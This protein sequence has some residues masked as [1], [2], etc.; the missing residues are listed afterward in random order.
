MLVTDKFV[1]LHLPRTGGTFVY[2]VVTRFFPSAREIGYHLPRELLP[3]EFSGLPILGTV[4]NPWD[5]Y[6][7]WY[8][9]QQSNKKYSRQKNILFGCLSNDRQHGFAETIQNALDLG[10]NDNKLDE[11]ILSVPDEVSYRERH[12]PNLTKNLVSRIRGSGLGLYT[13]RFNQLFGKADDVFFCR[14]ESLRS[15]LMTF[16]EKI[17]A[18]TEDL[19]NYVASLDKKNSSAHR[20]YSTYYTPALAA[21]VSLRDRQLVERFGFTFEDGAA[22]S[23]TKERPQLTKIL[24]TTPVAENATVPAKNRLLVV[25]SREKRVIPLRMGKA[26]GKVILSGNTANRFGRRALAVPVD[27]YISAMWEPSDTNRG[28]AIVWDSQKEDGVWL[29]TVRKI[30]RLIE[31]QIGP[32]SGRLTIHNTLPLGRGMG[33]STAIV[34]AL[35]RCFLGNHC[36]AEALAIEDDIN[37]GHSGL[38]FAAIW[39]ARPVIIQGDRYA[40]T[41]LPTG[42]QHGFLIDTGLPEMPT[43]I[44]VRRLKERLLEDKSLMRSVDIIGNCTERLLGGEHPLTVYPDHHREFVKLGLIPRNVCELV[45]KIERSGGAAKAGRFGGVTGGVGMLF[46]VHPEIQD[47]KAVVKTA[48]I[49]VSYNARDHTFVAAHPMGQQ[50]LRKGLKPAAVAIG[51]Y[52]T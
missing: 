33:S 8:H 50:Y 46:V 11:L 36:K 17:G 1:F 2:D 25:S 7:S 19:R 26:C 41:D 43:S 20:H 34:V 4:R 14:V 47:L 38:D 32:V 13:F 40:I 48:P 24:T 12:V 15:D 22:E 44:I 21:L 49:A 9:H 42:L 23:R 5:F 6:A 10:V 29:T 35:A 52:Y 37:K 3:K 18:A 30:M 51:E 31:A 28:L 39:E 27:M 16:F 45:E